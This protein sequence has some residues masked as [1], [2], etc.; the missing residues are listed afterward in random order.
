VF[1]ARYGLGLYLEQIT[2]VTYM[3]VS[4]ILT[5]LHFCEQFVTSVHTGP[6]LNLQNMP[7]NF[8]II[9]MFPVFKLKV[10]S[11]VKYIHLFVICFRTCIRHA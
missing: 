8:V 10:L 1:T 11:G 4:N 5:V 6:S 9:Y 7:P 2:F 3:S